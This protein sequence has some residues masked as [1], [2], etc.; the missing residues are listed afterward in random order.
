MDTK[1]DL[2]WTRAD[3]ILDGKANGLGEPIL[4]HLAL[5]GHGISMLTIANRETRTGYRHE[6]GRISD[7]HSP[8]GMMYRAY[9][10]GVPNAAQNI[11]MTLFNVGDLWGYRHW[12]R[13]AA[14][15]NETNAEWEAGLFETRMPHR[16]ARRLRRLRPYRRDGS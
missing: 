1:E 13:R 5:R 11:A 2:L 16:L 12:I 6:L 14:R 3:A 8:M 4:W 15:A 10:R 7:A 9:R